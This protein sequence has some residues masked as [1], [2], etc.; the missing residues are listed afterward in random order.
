MKPY[1]SNCAKIVSDALADGRIEKW[2]SAGAT[3]AQLAQC[4]GISYTMFKA[5]KAKNPSIA[6]IIQRARRPVVVEAFEGL[7]RL[8]HGYHEK[9]TKKHIRKVKDSSGNVISSVEEITEDDVYVPPS[10][11]A[12]TKVVVNYIN[13][14]KKYGIGIPQEYASEPSITIETKDGRLPEME[15][16]MR[17]LFFNGGDNEDN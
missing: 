3:D 6:T 1:A 7:V 12:C 15:Q 14:M 16:A 11:Q 9:V 10:H 8:S 17:E 13:Q 4:L 5:E 2:A